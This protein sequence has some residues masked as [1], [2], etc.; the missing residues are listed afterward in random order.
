M[1]TDVVILIPSF[2]ADGNLVDL[3]SSLHAMGFEKFVVVRDGDD[4]SYDNIYADVQKVGCHLLTHTNNKGKGA[5]LKTGFD[6]INAQFPD[7]V[8]VVTADADGQH[9]PEDILSMAKALQQSPDQFVLG[10]RKFDKNV[11]L[12][13]KLGNGLT[14]VLFRFLVGMKI[15]DTQSGLRAIPYVHLPLMLDISGQRY[16]YELNMLLTIHKHGLVITEV[17]IETVYLNDNIGSSFNPLVDSLIIYKSLLT[18]GFSGIASFAIDITLFTAIFYMFDSVFMATFVSRS[19]SLLAN[20]AMN[21]TY[22]FSYQGKSTKVFCY[23]LLNC[24]FSASVSYLLLEYVVTANAFPIVPFKIAI[25]ILLFL[26]N[27][28]IQNNFIFK[29]THKKATILSENNI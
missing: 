22:V 24:L 12:R 29:S 14:T 16:E 21:K 4:D 25:D 6:Y 27:F 18:Y 19:V 11:P 17:P 9:T 23:Y 26:V 13:S 10:A 20:F 1:I 15:N 8:G 3:M 5:A 7:I 28:H 2:K